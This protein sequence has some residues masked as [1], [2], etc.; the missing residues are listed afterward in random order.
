[1]TYILNMNIYDS[2]E[3]LRKDPDW[4]QSGLAHFYPSMEE[5]E[6]RAKAFKRRAQVY[7]PDA[8]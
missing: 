2:I 1:M 8:S 7:D 6:Q 4:E 3:N 5:M